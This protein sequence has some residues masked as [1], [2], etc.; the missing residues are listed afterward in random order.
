MSSDYTPI[1]DY[2]A[3]GNLRSVALV[4]KTGSIDWC[5]WPDLDSASVFA[6]ILDRH[7]GG[8]FRVAPVGLTS[9]SQRYEPGTNILETTLT[10]DGG[11]LVLTDFMPLDDSGMCRLLKCEGD[12]GLDVEV[13]WSPR[14]DYARARTEMAGTTAWSGKQR[15]NL[16]GLPV[17]PEIR[18]E[19]GPTLY[20]RF[21]MQAGQRVA[22]FSGHKP[23]MNAEHAHRKTRAMWLKW[24]KH[25]IEGPW[26]DQLV[27]SG[28]A[29]KLLTHAH[30]GALAAAA[31]TSL[32]EAIGG[33]RNWDYRYTWI[34]DAAFTVQALFSLGHHAEGRGFLKWVG[35]VSEPLQVMYGLHG[36]TDLPEIELTH[37]EGYRGSRPVRIGNAAAQQMQLDIYGEFI[38]AAYELLR[39]GARIDAAVWRLLSEIVDLAIA[40]WKEPDFGIWEVRGGPKQFV[41]SKVMVW[42]ALDRA[43]QLAKRFRFKGPVAKWQQIRD[44]VRDAVLTRGYDAQLGAFVQSFGSK[45]LDAA[46]LLIPIMG[47]LPFDDPRVRGTIDRTLERLTENGLVYRYLTDDGLPGAE[48][49]FGLATFWLVDV[50]ALSGR[51]DEAQEFMEGMAQRANHLGLFSE[52]FDPK[53]REF[54]GNFPQAFTH[55]GFV[56]A[57]VYLSHVQG[58]RPLEQA[59]M[60]SDEH[61]QEAGHE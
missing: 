7:K 6:A 43:I 41:Y 57:A 30:T 32:P 51:M 16:L 34:R 56:N 25:G 21:R 59:P 28:L 20:A 2:G 23:K 36:E 60:G 38:A 53:T 10:A 42:V 4:S 15:V 12:G 47:F 19:N 5:C 17:Q 3:I 54:L 18:E 27:R 24:V 37:F 9:T 55:T 39:R 44:E 61:R 1:A 45:A 48:G 13:E 58:G 26:H 40:Q 35:S 33:V 14:F 49:A 29:L 8:R 46:N 52:E 22:L 31:T 11:R 50:L